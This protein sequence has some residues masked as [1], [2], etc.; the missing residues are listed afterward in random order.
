[1]QKN[2]NSMLAQKIKAAREQA[3]LSREQLAQV[4]FL[5]KSTIDKWEQAK[6]LPRIPELMSLA[7]ILEVPVSSFLE[8][9]KEEK[10]MIKQMILNH[11]PIRD[12]EAP[13][14]II[15]RGMS[16]IIPAWEAYYRDFDAF[17]THDYQDSADTDLSAW[18]EKNSFRIYIHRDTRDM[19][20]LRD[21][22][23]YQPQLVDI[24]FHTPYLPIYSHQPETAAELIERAN[25][26]L[27]QFE[28]EVQKMFSV[29]P[30]KPLFLTEYLGTNHY[31]AWSLTESK[32]VYVYDYKTYRKN[33][34]ISEVTI[35]S[36]DEIHPNREYKIIPPTKDLIDAIATYDTDLNPVIWSR[37]MSWDAWDLRPEKIPVSLNTKPLAG[38]YATAVSLINLSRTTDCG[39]DLLFAQLEDRVERLERLDSLMAPDTILASEADMVQQTVDAITSAM[40]TQPKI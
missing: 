6:N 21:F 27:T 22:G 9:R 16:E 31:R 32:D 38:L 1:M 37:K 18:D 36:L 5:S 35:T 23:M 13:K 39:L 4:M 30:A 14:T 3:G 28:E 11:V 29:Y 25:R 40:Q 26:T 7:Q 33:F 24:L 10:N 17:I 19:I 15:Y 20:A 8:D 34:N 2:L 12:P